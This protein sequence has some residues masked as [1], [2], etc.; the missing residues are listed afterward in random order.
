MLTSQEIEIIRTDWRAVEG[1]AMQAATLFYDRL[2]EL[3]PTL[4]RL[5]KADLSDQKKKL[6][7]MLGAA[8][9]RLDD[10]PGLVPAVQSLGQRHA[11]YGVLPAHYATVG[12]ALLWTLHAGLGV[13]FNEQHESAWAKLYG[14]L[15]ETMQASAAEARMVESVS[16]TLT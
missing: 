15:S 6:L 7:Q 9:A 11:G 10:L 8:I 4:R 3:D 2:F 12:A 5:F 1:I 13:T 14:V 16:V